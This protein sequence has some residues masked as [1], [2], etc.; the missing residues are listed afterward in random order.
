[1][2][3]QWLSGDEWW[4]PLPP[5]ASCDALRILAARGIRAFG[6]GYVALLLPIYLVELA[7]D[8]RYRNQHLNRHRAFDAMGRMDR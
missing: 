6:D 5:E 8:R 3:G 1:M 4:R 2:R 7:R